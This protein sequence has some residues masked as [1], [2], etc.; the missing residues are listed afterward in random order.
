[1]KINE[2]KKYLKTLNQEEMINLIVQLSKID[3]KNAAFLESKYHQGSA[4]TAL[5]NE[6]K[7]KMRYVFFREMLP[8]L[9]KAKS[10]ISDLRKVAPKS[11]YLLDLQ[12]YYVECGVD[13]TNE[14]GDID[15]NFY[16]SMA[17]VFSEFV[18]GLNT[19][20]SKEF[21]ISVRPRISRII[22]ETDGIGWGFHEDL[23]E[24]AS[25]I[26]WCESE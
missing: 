1:M 19:F 23:C 14:Y 22:R 20:G 15:A 11:E 6:Y 24:A 12:L 26:V 18:H 7:L 3:K 2:L 8:T 10:F 16:Y 21:Y 25:E 9:K 17:S 13:F 5:V 4:E